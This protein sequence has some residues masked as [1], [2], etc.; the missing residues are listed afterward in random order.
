MKRY[1]V[2][3][4]NVER[5]VLIKKEKLKKPTNNVEKKMQYNANE[6]NREKLEI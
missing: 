4:H 6:N 1:G 5:P 2:Y 3:I